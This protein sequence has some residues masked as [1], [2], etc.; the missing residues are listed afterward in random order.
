M[1]AHV[2]VQVWGAEGSQVSYYVS[3]WVRFDWILGSQ[4]NTT[5]DDEDEN[6]V[7]E[8]GVMDEAVA[9]NSQTEKWHRETWIYT[10]VGDLGQCVAGGT[11]NYQFFF[12]RI[13]KE[14]PSGIGTI[15]SFGPENS[16]FN[17][18]TPEKNTETKKGEKVSWHV[19]RRDFRESLT[20][21]PFDRPQLLV[22]LPVIF[23]VLHTRKINS[24]L[25][26]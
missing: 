14:L 8:V 12:P 1:V 23:V 21:Q 2:F 13:K 22:L 25:F 26:H 11:S 17:G 19:S 9:G 3:E 18:A 20:F 16:G 6:E 4:R 24:H 15:F 5:E 10:R 7:G